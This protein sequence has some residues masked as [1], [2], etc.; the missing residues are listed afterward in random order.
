MA[1]PPSFMWKDPVLKKSSNPL[2]LLYQPV[3]VENRGE[4]GRIPVEEIFRRVPG[5]ELVAKLQDLGIVKYS[6]SHRQY[7]I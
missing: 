5:K 4:V 2:S 7:P 1:Q 6:L 3:D